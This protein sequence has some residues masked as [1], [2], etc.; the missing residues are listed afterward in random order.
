MYLPMPGWLSLDPAPRMHPVKDALQ[1]AFPRCCDALKPK[2][3]TALLPLDAPLMP[4]YCYSS[5]SSKKHPGQG[6]FFPLSQVSVAV[7]MFLLRLLISAMCSMWAAFE[8]DPETATSSETATNSARLLA[9]VDWRD[10]ITPVPRGLHWLPI[11]SQVRFK[12]L[13]LNFKM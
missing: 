9:E 11:A 1:V 6:A 2:A 10:A 12:V 7:I 3:P 13:V 4:R 5:P 8:D